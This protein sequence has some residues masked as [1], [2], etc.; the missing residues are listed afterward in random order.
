MAATPLHGQLC[1]KKRI[2]NSA[3]DTAH[4]YKTLH[5][6]YALAEK[7]L[8]LQRK[9]LLLEAAMVLT[10]E[11]QQEELRYYPIGLNVAII[12]AGAMSG[13]LMRCLLVDVH[14]QCGNLRWIKHKLVTLLTGFTYSLSF[15]MVKL[16]LI[17]RKAYPEESVETCRIEKYL[18]RFNDREG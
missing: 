1:T 6:V 10:R 7:L 15:V 13:N 17:L 9:H 18:E 8:T 4:E 12:Y 11:F 3:D 5:R 2:D 16:N 14:T